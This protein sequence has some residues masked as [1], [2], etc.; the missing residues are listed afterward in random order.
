MSTPLVATHTRE[1]RRLSPLHM[2]MIA[3]LVGNILVNI[4]LQVLIVR[5]LIVPLSIILALTLVIA[6]IVAS[7][8]RWA[9]LLAA[10]W[11]IVSVVPGLEPYTYNLTHPSETGKFIATLLGLSL[12]LVTVVAGVAATFSG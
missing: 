5:E 8:W 7:R 4:V 2:V 9:P 1:R 3:G 6:G 11:C 12:L 10:L